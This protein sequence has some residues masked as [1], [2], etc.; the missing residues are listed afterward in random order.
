MLRATTAG[1]AGDEGIRRPKPFTYRSRARTASSRVQFEFKCLS[2]AHFEC[3]MM[4]P[5]RHHIRSGSIRHR[6][7]KTAILRAEPNAGIREFMPGFG[8]T[9][10]H[11]R[12]RLSKQRA[13]S[14]SGPDEVREIMERRTANGRR[15]PLSLMAPPHID[16]PPPQSCGAAWQ[17]LLA[18][19]RRS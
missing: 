9:N 7:R 10:S 19:T 12:W 4:T 8:S 18:L 6:E 16:Q 15:R 1:S 5:G 13:S 2:P 3:Q 14:W 17:T 11:E